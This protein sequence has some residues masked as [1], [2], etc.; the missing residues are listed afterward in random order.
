MIN[1]QVFFENGLDEKKEID[2]DF[3]G[4]SL[5]V[6][7]ANAFNSVTTHEKDK[8]NH[9]DDVPVRFT[10]GCKWINDISIPEICFVLTNDKAA[11]SVANQIKICNMFS[12]FFLKFHQKTIHDYLIGKNISYKVEFINS[13][14]HGYSVN[15]VNKKTIF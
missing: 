10:E 4:I 3:F 14:S 5:Q 7:V 11:I 8:I 2:M 6:A 9:S 12:D 15:H 13:V 1:L